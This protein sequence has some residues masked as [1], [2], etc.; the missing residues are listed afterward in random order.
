MG[1][2][3]NW[4]VR[5]NRS[6]LKGGDGEASALTSLAVLYEVL[7]KMAVIMAPF[8]PF[9]AEY[10]YQ[11][12]RKRLTAFSSAN[13]APD[14]LGRA[15][16]VH[17]IMLPTADNSKID[18]RAV[19]GM[20]LLQRVVELGRRARE[21]ASISMKTPIREVIV[22]CGDKTALEALQASLE[23]YVLE[24]LN[25]WGVSFTSDVDLWCSVSALPNL[26]V[27]AKRLGKKMS[28]ATA[29]IK[30][31]DSS[32]L[33]SYVQYGEI[34]VDVD[35][36]SLKLVSG[37]LIVKSAFAG[38][39]AK[40]AATTAPDGSL[41]VAIC[42]VQDD[43]LR[44]QGIAR[45]VCNRVN[46][47]RKKA[48]LDIIDQVDVFYADLDSADATGP[49]IPTADAL[50]H[51]K[52]L[53]QR[54]KIVPIPLS[55][56]FGQVIVTDTY[57]TPFGSKSLKIA[58]AAPSL[59]LPCATRQSQSSPTLETL[60]ASCGI[61]QNEYL[62]GTFAGAQFDLAFGADIFTSATAAFLATS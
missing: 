1:D 30:N 58:L 27:L 13:A 49:S 20:S 28:A 21:T 37:E 6:R 61:Q 54:A 60:V 3:T 38:N 45:D 9:F 40:Y 36:M 10:L 11:Q 53:L 31:L 26:P 34:N 46:K 2:L 4:Y 24:E 47:L 25:A 29:V 17:Y 62:R 22:V 56:C 18:D 51:N 8:T 44:R 52:A 41:T 15:D 42:T 55:R 32:A 33:R 5:L 19:M 23:S 59:S 57:P 12:L 39:E 7:L 50:A 16:S 48:R 43:D 14:E 35:G